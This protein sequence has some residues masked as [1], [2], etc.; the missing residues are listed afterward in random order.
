MNFKLLLPVFLI[1]S[2]SPAFGQLSDATGL[3][4][5]FDIETGGHVFEVTTTAN[6]DVT[7]V[8]FDKDKKQLTLYI[9]SSIE[10]NLGEIIIPSNF[11]SGNFTFY[12]NDVEY[13]PKLNTNDRIAF[14][15]LNFTGTGENKVEIF[16]T[17]Y[18][19]GVDEIKQTNSNQTSDELSSQVGGG[20]CLIATA[21]FDSELAPQVQ[22]LREIRDTK[23]LKTEFGSQFMIYF[24]EFYY[25]FSPTI[26]DLQREEPVFKEFVKL[27][28][29]PMLVSLSLLD[30]VE[31][32]SDYDVIGYGLGI[33]SLNFGLM[34]KHMALVLPQRNQYNTLNYESRFFYH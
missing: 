17:N 20:G 7:A 18:L 16:A 13:H 33:I 23:L 8:E 12:L 29:T 6:F 27:I 22:Q 28:I 3:V 14:I 19:E 30:L 4:N 25:S 26:A 24:N 2:F 34:P 15:T 21:T 10:N 11:L 32:N 5:R 31:I 9:V 1:I